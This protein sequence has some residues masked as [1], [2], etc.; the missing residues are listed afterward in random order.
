[1]R[2]HSRSRLVFGVLGLLLTAGL[3]SA[4]PVETKLPDGL[5]HVPADAMSFVHFRVVD[6]LQTPFGKSMLAE[7]RKDRE[8]AKGLKSMEDTWGLDATE[9][10]SVTLIMLPLPALNL[11]DGPLIPD[12]N[13]RIPGK[14]GGW[15]LKAADAM[16]L[17]RIAEEAAKFK[18]IEMERRLQQEQQRLIEELR[19]REL[20]E[21]RRQE[22]KK[23][24]DKAKDETL[25]P[26]LFQERPLND[27]LPYVEQHDRRDPFAFSGLVIVTATKPLDRKKMMRPLI[28]PPERRGFDDGPRQE[29]S[30]LFLSDRS[31]MIG[32]ASELA[33]YSE[34]MAR[35][36]PPK[37]RPMQTALDMAAKPHLMVAGS[38]VP[39]D[40]A[41]FYFAPFNPQA[42]Q[43]A[44]V[45]PLFH[46]EAGLALD[47]GTSID[48]TVQ[49]KAPTEAAA[50]NALQAAKTLVVLAELAL[51]KSKD[52]GE[53]GGWKLDLEKGLAK[54][55]ADARIE[56]DGLTARAKLKMDLSPTITKHVS[57]EIIAS[58][59]QRGD[60]AGHVNNLKQIGLAIHSYHDAN[61]RLPPA[62]FSSLKNGDGKPLLSWRVAILPFIDQ[63]PLYQQFDLDQPWD[64]P[65]NKKL[66]AK[67]PAVYMMPG[68]ETKEGMTHY[69]T[70]VGPDTMLQPVL[71]PGGR[72]VTR[73]ALGNIPDGTSN[74]IMV[75]EAKEPTIWTKP[76]DL[77][78][79]PNGPLPKFGV[80]PD[81]FHV[82][83]G[84]ASVRFLRS[85]ISEQTLRN[86][87]TCSD[88]NVLG[89]DW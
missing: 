26:V 15:K 65:T 6:F 36:E 80:Y 72:L 29:M 58:F 81:G 4:Q 24:D 74:T 43:M 32:P 76:D 51:E 31:V 89:P 16:Q 56:Q 83:L 59:R 52:G 2:M 67:M 79:N 35:K 50:A 37:T 42:T 33:R 49:F 61:K 17:R 11:W 53:S 39:A 71:A 28:F 54:A 44:A 63:Q 20:E 66:I 8:A 55:L 75:V 45:A 73:Y 88:G 25:A 21:K 12:L 62:A 57:K 46:T 19:R 14:V 27:L 69:R 85:T 13:R 68:V 34:L 87:I 84:D 47:L 40:F 22:E 86:A 70:L 7:L 30:A 3:A 78:Y 41:R 9:V 23:K 5:R 60:R 64:H 77:P 1:M 18:A 38:H 82:L 48:L 10:E